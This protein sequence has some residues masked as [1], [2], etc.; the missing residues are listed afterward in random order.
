MTESE[1]VEPEESVELLIRS[2]TR[3]YERYSSLSVQALNKCF[4]HWSEQ[5][6]QLPT[7]AVIA[8]VRNFHPH[9][10]ILQRFDEVFAAADELI[11]KRDPQSRKH[12]RGLNHLDPRSRRDNSNQ[13][14]A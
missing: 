1:L 3:D 5:I 2:L 9:A 14:Q 11:K 4:N 13:E 6:D 8:L 12:F 7:V 10:K